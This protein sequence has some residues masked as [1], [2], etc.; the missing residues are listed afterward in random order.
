MRCAIAFPGAT[1]PKSEQTRRTASFG[2]VG[3]LPARAGLVREH[4]FTLLE[5]LTAIA[6][7]SVAL[8][9]TAQL[10]GA[11]ATAVHAARLST[12]AATLA[13]ARMEE[14][15]SL[16]W[17]FDVSGAP[18]SDVTTNLA[19]GQP[20]L[21]G[22]GLTP[23]PP[24]TLDQNTAGYVDFL[25]ANGTWVS[26]G[27]AVP[28]NAIFVRRWAIETPADG[29]SDSLVLRVVVRPVAFH[30]ARGESRLLTLRTRLAR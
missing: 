26:A 9:S 5:V 11:T 28:P 27:P 17:G 29:S 3:R 30:S 2:R 25:D 10:L 19:T 18:V 6:L 22:G 21:T 1:A 13:A 7:L 24:G 23:S 20:S 4:G 8:L 14:L 12:T 16:T 15:R